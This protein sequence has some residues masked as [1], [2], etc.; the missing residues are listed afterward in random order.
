[1]S[2]KFSRYGILFVV[3]A[4]S[5]AGKTTLCDALRQTPDFVY[6]V[7][8]TTRPARSGEIDGEDYRF[9]SKDDFLARMKTGE[10]LEHAKVHEHY[11]GTLRQPLVDNLKKGVDVLIDID[12]QGAAAIRNCGDPFV[13]EALTDVFIMPPNL[14]ELRRRLTKRGTETVQQIE[15]RL[16]TAAREMKLWRDYRYTIIS[17]SMEEDLQKFRQI[18]GAERILSRR[19]ILQ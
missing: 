17:K 19:L 5:G 14:E 12:T 1:M 15:A 18:M 11:Y 10:F 4:P 13:R 2:N 7:S 3:S 16:K 8:C 6:S 9:L